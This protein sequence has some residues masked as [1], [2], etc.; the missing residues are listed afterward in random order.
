MLLYLGALSPRLPDVLCPLPQMPH[1]APAVLTGADAW[2]PA[3]T[4]SLPEPTRCDVVRVSWGLP[5][6]KGGVAEPAAP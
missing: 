5:R 4:S 3:P 2:L 6:G 1:Q